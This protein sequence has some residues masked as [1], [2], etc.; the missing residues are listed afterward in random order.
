MAKPVIEEIIRSVKINFNSQG[1]VNEHAPIETE[2]N[3]NDENQENIPYLVLPY[4]GA[5][6]ENII[7]GFKKSLSR[8]LPGKRTRISFNGKKIS[9]FFPIKDRINWRHK[10]NLIYHFDSGDSANSGQEGRYVGETKVR[11]ESRIN[12]HAGRDRFSSVLRHSRQNNYE[13][14]EDNFEILAKGYKNTRERKIAEAMYIR[15]LK[16]NLNEQIQSYKLSLFK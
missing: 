1:M 15:D 12:G 2:D 16:P 7:K 10:S 14:T 11:F 4:K 5:R 9:N 6:G 8:F 3:N 13:V